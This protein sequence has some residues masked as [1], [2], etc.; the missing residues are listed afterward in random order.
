MGP[1][2]LESVYTVLL[3]QE[4]ARRGLHVERNRPLSF[5]YDGLRFDRGLRIDLLVD[6]RVVVEL[7][8]VEKLAPVHAKQILTYV[9]LLQLPV[10]LLINFGGATL[11]EGIQRVVN[12]YAPDSSSSLRVNSQVGDM[13]HERSTSSHPETRRR[14]G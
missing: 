3:G 6:H 10:G 11:K 8:S 7:K 1:G 5:E 9:R 12:R 14:G 13:E 2:L 4:L